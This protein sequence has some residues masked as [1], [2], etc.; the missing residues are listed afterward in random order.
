MGD[1]DDWIPS[2]AEVVA[3]IKATPPNPAMIRQPQGTFVDNS[4]DDSEFDLEA[5]KREWA[6]AEEELRR[7]NG[8]NNH[9]NG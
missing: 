2:V 3:R 1:E 5:W 4:R 7:A 6:Y 9:N 8:G